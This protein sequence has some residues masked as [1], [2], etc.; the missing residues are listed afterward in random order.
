MTIDSV[1]TAHRAFLL[2]LANG[3]Q[4]GNGAI[5]AP[6]ARLD[7][8]LLDLVSVEAPSRLQLVGAIPRLFAGT[9]HKDPIVRIRRVTE[10]RITGA[11]PLLFH[12]DGEPARSEGANLLVRVHPGALIV[13]A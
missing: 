2:T 6:E 9:L 3:P 11:A 4:W 8:G 5:V 1:V 12:Y 10:A 13:R 7:D